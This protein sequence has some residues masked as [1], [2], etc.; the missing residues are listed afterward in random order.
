MDNHQSLHI[1]I[2]EDDP[3]DA[4]LVQENLRDAM[5]GQFT[6]TCVPS[7]AKALEQLHTTPFDVI[8]LDLNLPDR[9]GF[10]TFLEVQAQARLTPILILTGLDDQTLALRAV[11]AGAQDYLVKGQLAGHLLPRVIRDAIERHR[12]QTEIY[13]LSMQDSLTGLYNRRGFL[14]LAEEQ[15][16]LVHRSQQGLLLFLCDVDGMKQINDALGH[17]EGDKALIDIAV[18]LHTT[19]RSSDIIARLSGDEFA[20]LAIGTLPATPE[21]LQARLQ[22]N[23]NKHN[24]RAKRLYELSLS[25]GMAYVAPDEQATLEELISKADQ[26]MYAH[27]RARRKARSD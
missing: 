20:I 25:V 24:A 1:L 21:L 3:A 5:D 9:Q 18:I 15:L 4:R 17:L 23:L 13:N 2:L 7:V 10:N 26:E 12:L 6:C 14:M 22:A 11:K 27:K 19:F 16:K 8:L